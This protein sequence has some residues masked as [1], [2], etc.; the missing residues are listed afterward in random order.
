M[1]DDSNDDNDSNDYNNVDNANMAGSQHMGLLKL[2]TLP[3]RRF[4]C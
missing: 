2:M 3:K 1:A 4:R